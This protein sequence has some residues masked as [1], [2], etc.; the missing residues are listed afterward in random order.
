MKKL[1][2]CLM[3]SLLLTVITNSTTGAAMFKDVSPTSVFYKAV[4]WSQQ[5]NLIKGYDTGKY[6]PTKKLAEA[7]FVVIFARLV[8]PLYMAHYK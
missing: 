5:M 1:L 8:D 2:I 4:E 6:E 7:Q 3:L